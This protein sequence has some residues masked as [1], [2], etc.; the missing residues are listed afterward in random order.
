[1]RYGEF[2]GGRIVASVGPDLTPSILAAVRGLTPIG[3]VVVKR[4]WW[5]GEL[6][7]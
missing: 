2:E 4:S 3:K 1:M 7:D 6:A 5:A